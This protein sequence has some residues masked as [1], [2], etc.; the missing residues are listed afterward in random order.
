LQISRYLDPDLIRLELETSFELED[1]ETEEE[2]TEKRR[3][4]RKEALLAEFAQLLDTSGKICNPSKLLTDLV[5][6]ERKATTAIGKGIAIPH[7]RTMQA[8]ELVVGVCRSRDG[9]DFDSPDGKAVHLFVPMA[10]PPYDDN[11][12][13]RVFKALAE[14]FHYDGFIDRVMEAEIPYDI[15]RVFQDFE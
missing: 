2:L 3:F 15:I 10:A 12:Y 14:L 8:R 1:E 13:L 11:L 6:R 7:I 4:E 9:F 5:N